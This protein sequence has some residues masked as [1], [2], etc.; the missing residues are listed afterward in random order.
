MCTRASSLSASI[1]MWNTFLTIQIRRFDINKRFSM[2]KF[3]V[4]N[5]LLIFLCSNFMVITQ[6]M[7]SGYQSHIFE[8]VFCLSLCTYPNRICFVSD[9]LLIKLDKYLCCL[10]CTRY[11]FI[12]IEITLY[13]LS[14]FLGF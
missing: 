10:P 7:C 11:N 12:N 2:R 9:F 8:I 14:S 4:E 6:R 1:D 13:I 5:F 3:R